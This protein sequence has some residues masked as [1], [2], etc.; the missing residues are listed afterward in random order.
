[1][2]ELTTLFTN[3]ANAIRSKK[4]TTAQI[5]AANFPTE[6]NSITGENSWVGDLTITGDGVTVTDTHFRGASRILFLPQQPGSQYGPADYPVIVGDTGK[7]ACSYLDS[8]RRFLNRALTLDSTNGKINV[9]QISGADYVRLG[10]NG[11]YTF[12]CIY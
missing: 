4:G 2:S 3:I 10:A 1:M 7:N 5:S 8:N 9:T 12:I 6:I 11:R